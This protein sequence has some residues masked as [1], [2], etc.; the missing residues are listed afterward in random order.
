MKRADEAEQDANPASTADL[1]TSEG[2]HSK[3][4]ESAIIPQ[5]RS[6]EIK[7]GE[8][9]LHGN[10]SIVA[11]PAL[12]RQAQ[13]LQRALSVATGYI[14]PI[15]D[16]G[17]GQR[18]ELCLSPSLARLGPEGYE[19]DVS[20]R[21]IAIRASAEA[22]VFYAIQS[23]L[24]LM[25]PEIFGPAG[26]GNVRWRVPC[27][28]IEDAPRFSW[29]G[30]LLDMARHYLPKEFILKM[31]D[32]MA[33]YK[34]NVLQLHLTDDQG[35]RI[36]IKRYPRLTEIG[37]RGDHSASRTEEATRAQ[38]QHPGGF[39]TQQD[40]REIVRYAADRFIT[41]VPEIE[42]PGHAGAAILAYP[43]LGK[44]GVFN[45]QDSTIGA[46]KNVL[47]EVLELFPSKF[48]HL[49]GDE[50][51]DTAWKNDEQAEQRMRML[52]L[53]NKT[54]LQSWFVKQFDS[55]LTARGRRLVGWDEILEGGLAPGAAVMSWR[56]TAGGVAAVKAGHHAIMAPA[57]ETYFDAY[58]RKPTALEPRAIGNYLPLKKVYKFEPIVP[59]L[60]AD[61]SKRVLGAQACLWGEF[62]SQP[63]HAE[64]MVFPRL[65]AFAEAVWSQPRSRNWISFVRR[66]NAHFKKLDILQV[67]YCPYRAEAAEV[68]ATNV[69]ASTASI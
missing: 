4:S 24:L 58:Q 15:V 18:I 35:W 29:R 46:L 23:L 49:G 61:E 10:A 12:V 57:D 22:G 47:D 42:M 52:G 25:P 33:L 64:Y 69:S 59:T 66:L 67:N 48:V 21:R 11:D 28:A 43:E 53:R 7:R 27:V 13:L 31:L 54:E 19:L 34:L 68:A 20:A 40:L 56:G 5:P 14:L 1:P 65:L 60:S 41:V 2:V 63:K 16:R 51:P 32:L 6:V 37:A 44:D 26:I 50:V 8:F 62:V 30:L 3:E 38:N 39:Y 36:E 55:Y 17:Q 45:V 9:Q